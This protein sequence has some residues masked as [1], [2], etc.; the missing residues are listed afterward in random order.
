M[1]IREVEARTTERYCT[2]PEFHARVRVAAELTAT[3]MRRATGLSPSPDFMA[4]VVQSCA[5]G[6][7]MAE[8]DITSNLDEDNIANMRRTAEALGFQLI[9]GEKPNG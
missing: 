4:G 8:V 5:Y 7:M 6:L 9:Q 3:S 2:D 1:D